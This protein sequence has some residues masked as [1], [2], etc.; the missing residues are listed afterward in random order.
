MFKF[1]SCVIGAQTHA[2]PRQHTLSQ[3]MCCTARSRSHAWRLLAVHLHRS[4]PC[5]AWPARCCSCSEHCI[6]KPTWVAE[7]LKDDAAVGSR[8]AHLRRQDS[9]A[10]AAHSPRRRQVQVLHVQRQDIDDVAACPA[11][12]RSAGMPGAAIAGVGIAGPAAPGADA[13]RRTAVLQRGGSP[14]VSGSRAAT[15]CC[16]MPAVVAAELLCL[17][18]RRHRAACMHLRGHAC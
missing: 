9:D 5:A 2:A 16:M 14:Q 12:Q 8:E 10:A 3:H 15:P 11:A 1:K 17:M 13:G 7:L 4:T 18:R 6:A